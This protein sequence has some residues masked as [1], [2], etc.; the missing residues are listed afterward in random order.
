[1][2]LKADSRLFAGAVSRSGLI[3]GASIRLDVIVD[4]PQ[5]LDGIRQCAA[6]GRVVIQ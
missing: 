2:S 6:C 4:L 1:V 3:Q 5:T